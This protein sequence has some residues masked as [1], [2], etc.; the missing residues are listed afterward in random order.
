MQLGL[1]Q[2][3]QSC[4]NDLL[5]MLSFSVVNTTSWHTF[6]TLAMKTTYILVGYNR[7]AATI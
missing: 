7:T 1:K 3:I 2:F 4:P 6:K 5:S